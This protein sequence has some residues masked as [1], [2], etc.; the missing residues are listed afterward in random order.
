MS[1]DRIRCVTGHF[2]WSEKCYNAFHGDYRFVT[3]LR[4]PVDRFVSNYLYGRY[5]K[6]SD[7]HRIRT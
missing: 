4:N 6:H 7:F 2:L 5:K 1:D 3:L